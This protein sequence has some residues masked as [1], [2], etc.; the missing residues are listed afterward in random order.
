MWSAGKYPLRN[1]NSNANAQQQK[2]QVRNLIDFENLAIIHQGATS[3]FLNNSATCNL[4]WLI[5]SFY[6]NAFKKT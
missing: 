2:I 4:C 1:M 5:D 6:I 3:G